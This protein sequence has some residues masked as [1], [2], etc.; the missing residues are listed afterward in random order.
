MAS[1]LEAL[2]GADYYGGVDSH[3]TP[4]VLIDENRFR[5]VSKNRSVV[6]PLLEEYLIHDIENTCGIRRGVAGNIEVS[7]PTGQ[8]LFLLDQPKDLLDVVPSHWLDPQPTKLASGITWPGGL[9]RNLWLGTTLRRDGEQAVEDLLEMRVAGR[10]LVRQK[11]VGNASEIAAPL[12]LALGGWRCRICGER[13]RAPRPE[14]CQRWK[15][16]CSEGSIEPLV[17]WVAD[18][19]G[20]VAGAA[21]AAGCR[22][23]LRNA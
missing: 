17:R 20:D 7:T 15:F 2:L 5:K 4:L 16:V 22:L 23:T 14:Q 3:T 21:L 12:A 13:G 6:D 9:P 8:W 10:F 11:D 18:E 1:D 19:V